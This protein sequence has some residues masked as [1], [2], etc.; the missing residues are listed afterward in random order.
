MKEHCVFDPALGALSVK[1]LWIEDPSV[2]KDNFKSALACQNRMEARQL[3]E[4]TQ[5]EYCKQ[6]KDMIQRGVV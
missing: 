3:K 5:G 2:L 4:G 1:Y 6:F